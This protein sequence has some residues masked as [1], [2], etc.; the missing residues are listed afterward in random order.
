MTFALDAVTV[1]GSIALLLSLGSFVMKR[2]LPL[3]LLAMGANVFFIAFGLALLSQPGQDPKGS[4]PGMLLNGLLLPINARRAWEIRKLTREIARATE[5][6]P[7]SQWLLPHMER[8]AFKPGEVLFRRGDAAD[9]LLY[10]ASGTLLLVEIGKRVEPGDLLGE[11]GLF[12]ADNSRTQTLQ[13]V[14]GG[15]VYEMTGEML[16]QLHYQNPRLGFYMMRLLTQR[17]LQDVRR[18]AEP[19]AV[20]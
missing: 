1:F 13:A 2:M 12:S 16:F 11:I 3:R 19:N 10:I 15:D 7:V 9:R 20:E 6:S 17:L 18:S 5:N 14:T 4:I 8:R